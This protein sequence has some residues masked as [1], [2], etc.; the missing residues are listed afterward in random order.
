MPNKRKY[1]QY[2]E[3]ECASDTSI[4]RTTQWRLR[5]ERPRAPAGG[6]GEDRRD[7]GVALAI[8]KR[9]RKGTVDSG[10]ESDMRDESSYDPSSEDEV[11]SNTEQQP[12]E[13]DSDEH[14]V[15]ANYDG[16][17]EIEDPG[18]TCTSDSEE[19]ETD[20]SSDEESDEEIGQNNGFADLLEENANDADLVWICSH[21]V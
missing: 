18:I 15:A 3:P 20:S 7:I 12:D 5:D 19:V 4:P 14:E 13:R 21:D 6:G 17:Q 11:I 1:K 9:Q 16:T 10:S 8:G 2:L